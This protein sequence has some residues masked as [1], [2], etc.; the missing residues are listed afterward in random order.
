MFRTIR[1]ASCTWISTPPSRST[2]KRKTGQDVEIKQSHGGSGKQARSVIDG[3]AADV[4]TLGLG[5][6]VD[7][8][9]TQ[10]KLLAPDW[11]KRLPDNSAPYTSTIIFAGAQGQPEEDQGLG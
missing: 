7:S 1:P 10:G 11:E 2:G 5:G 4:V 6:D 3:L 9:A 8:V